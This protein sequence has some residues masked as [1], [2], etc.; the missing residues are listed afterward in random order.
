MNVRFSAFCE[1]FPSLAFV[2]V[3][4]SMWQLASTED[5]FYLSVSL[6]MQDNFSILLTVLKL[7]ATQQ[8]ANTWLMFKIRIFRSAA[9]FSSK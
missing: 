7:L 1:D 9:A 2:A 6:P 8:I 4:M 5:D 3:K